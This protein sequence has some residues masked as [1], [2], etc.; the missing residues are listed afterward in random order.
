MHQ[1]SSFIISAN[2]RARVYHEPQ[3]RFARAVKDKYKKEVSRKR[4]RKNGFRPC[5]C[6][7]TMRFRFRQEQHALEMYASAK[8]LQVL[9]QSD[10]I[11]VRTPIG[12][13]MICFESDR[14]VYTLYHRNQSCKNLSDDILTLSCRFSIPFLIF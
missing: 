2:S 8:Q 7:S 1:P 6:C 13:W 12:I 5:K 11:V 14:R 9:C 4:A 3:C 10:S